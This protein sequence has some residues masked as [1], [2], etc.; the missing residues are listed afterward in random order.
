MQQDL[1]DYLLRE[2]CAH[3]NRIRIM[4]EPIPKIDS[5]PEL[6]PFVCVESD[7][8]LS[9]IREKKPIAQ[10]SLRDF[11]LVDVMPWLVLSM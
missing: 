8:F 5:A 9:K 2:S 10:W 1:I 7:E 3:I 4:V 11:A 6:K